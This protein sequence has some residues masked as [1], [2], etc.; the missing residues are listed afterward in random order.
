MLYVCMWQTVIVTSDCVSRRI[1]K[2]MHW[3]PVYSILHVVWR[4]FK[5]H[6]RKFGINRNT[7]TSK[8]NRLIYQYFKYSD[9][10]TPLSDINH[11]E[12]GIHSPVNQHY[13]Y[14]TKPTILIS[15]VLLVLLPTN[16]NVKSTH[17]IFIWTPGRHNVITSFMWSWYQNT[18]KTPYSNYWIYSCLFGRLGEH[19][20]TCM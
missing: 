16:I 20:M 13:M 7:G 6:T 3:L 10:R 11:Q 8:P 18:T 15:M 2:C 1:Y 17:Q 4:N 9:T 19:Y 12:T 5:C 14:C